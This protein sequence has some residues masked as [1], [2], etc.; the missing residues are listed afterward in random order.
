L[1][2]G[3]GK[4]AATTF[5]FVA[6]R[7]LLQRLLAAIHD[8]QSFRAIPVDLGLSANQVWGLAKTDEEW[9]EQLEA[10][11]T[12]TLRDD[13]R[14]GTTAAYVRG[15]VCWEPGASAGADGEESSLT[16]A[17]R[18]ASRAGHVCEPTYASVGA[19]TPQPP[20]RDYVV[21]P[22]PAGACWFA[23]SRPWTAT[24]TTNAAMTTLR[25]K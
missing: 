6:N 5:G 16:R 21:G 20:V 24:I 17:A 23:G 12:A 19:L 9:S 15:C 18:M 13:L 10:A 22:L 14:H 7:T 3:K 4:T 11:L 2:G 25:T 8:G 1:S